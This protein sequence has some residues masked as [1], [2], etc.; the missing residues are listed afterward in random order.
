M[1]YDAEKSRKWDWN[2]WSEGSLSDSDYRWV[3]LPSI[4][5]DQDI[6]NKYEELAR[7]SN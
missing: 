5:T 7:E 2:E 6:I 3:H 4:E 1:D